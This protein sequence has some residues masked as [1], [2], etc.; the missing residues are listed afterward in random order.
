VLNLIA[1]LLDLTRLALK[2]KRRLLEVIK[3]LEVN[4]VKIYAIIRYII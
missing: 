1:V 3:A 2:I 4:P